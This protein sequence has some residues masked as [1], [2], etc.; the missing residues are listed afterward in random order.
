MSNQQE[1]SQAMASA[2]L[3]YSQDEIIT[4]LKNISQEITELLSEKNPLVICIM[5]GGLVVSGY[6]LPML[7]FQLQ[8]DYLHATRYRGNTRGDKLE[9]LKKPSQS[10]QGRHVLLVDDI[11]DEGCTLKEVKSYCEDAGAASV[12]IAVLLDKK[13]DRRVAGIEADFIALQ[14]PD[15]YVFGFGMDYKEYWRNAPGVYA[16]TTELS[17]VDPTRNFTKA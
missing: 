3:V 14:V 2:R 12:S 15:D 1:A 7:N 8:L 4:S 16:V 11:L 5:N 17:E 9:W 10:L 6:L 13:H